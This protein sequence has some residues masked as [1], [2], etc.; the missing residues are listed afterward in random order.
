MELWNIKNA[1]YIQLTKFNALNIVTES[2]FKDAKAVI[3]EICSHF[4]IIKL[5][6]QFMNYHESTKDSNK[7]N[8][9]YRDYYLNE[10]WRDNLSKD[11]IAIINETI[12]K[13]LMAYFKYELLN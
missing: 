10:R 7:D 12:D 1:S 13:K 3:D 11:A 4:S 9:F 8:E 2:I 5:S 6:N